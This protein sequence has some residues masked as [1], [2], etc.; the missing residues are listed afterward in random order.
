MAKKGLEEVWD[1]LAKKLF[2]YGMGIRFNN[3]SV[4]FHLKFIPSW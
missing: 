4:L 3:M 1:K 2:V